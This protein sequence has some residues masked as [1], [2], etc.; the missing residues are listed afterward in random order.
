MFSNIRKKNLSSVNVKRILFISLIITLLT[1]LSVIPIVAKGDDS[2]DVILDGGYVA[3]QIG[4]TWDSKP[5]YQADFGAPEYLPDKKTKINT[6]WLD[7]GTQFE[8]GAN[9]FNAY[10]VGDTVSVWD[11]K[12]N[13]LTWYPNIKVSNSITLSKGKAKILSIDPLN[14]NYKNNTI[15]WNYGSGIVRRVRIIEGLIQEYYVISQPINGNF[16]IDNAITRHSSFKGKERNPIAW[17]V[18]NKS[19]NINKIGDNLTINLSDNMSY[20]VIIDPDITF[21]STASDNGLWGY[22]ATYSTIHNASSGDIYYAGFIGQTYYGSNYFIFRSFF[23]FDTASLGDNITITSANLSLYGLDDYSTTDFYM[24]I[25]D[26]GATYPHEPIQTGDYLYSNYSGDSGNLT[27]SGFTASGYNTIPLSAS[28]IAQIN[29]TGT[30]KFAVLSNRDIASTTPTG[31]EYVRVGVYSTGVGYRPKLNI[32]FTASQVGANTL[33]ASNIGQTTARL[34]STIMD[35]GGDN[36]SVRFGYGTTSQTAAN[37]TNYDN[38]TAWSDFIYV[39][40]DNPYLNVSG[41]T[42]ATTYYYRIQAKNSATNVTSATEISFTTQ[43]DVGDILNFYAIPNDTSI[44]LHWTF[45]LGDSNALILYRTDNYPDATDNGTE[46]YFGSNSSYTHLNLTSGKT[47]YYS[48]WGESGGNYS[49]NY[50]AL[51]MTT[52]L[53]TTSGDDIEAPPVP[54]RWVATPSPSGLSGIGAY[55]LLINEAL[56]SAEIPQAKGWMAIYLIAIIAIGMWIWMKSGK[57]FP[58]LVIVNLFMLLGYGIHLL[59][60]WMVAISICLLLAS[61]ATEWRGSRA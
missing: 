10:T 46:V 11:D 38:V 4:T 50:L 25:Q 18:N 3:H 57:I 9:L 22:N 49:S 51:A 59:S 42:A 60:G 19:I 27:T 32:T 47:Y 54:D 39:K 61:L 21:T 15:E 24:T 44:S 58:T 7:T 36:C 40:D 31:D 28:G 23:Y 34:N 55:Y 48:I 30:T 26:G 20:P 41:L 37:F 14:P 43:T 17:E 56:T 13:A 2:S 29:V 16:N 6:Q 53:P 35:D 52:G 33:S 45:G 8:S 12:Y 5:I 1:T